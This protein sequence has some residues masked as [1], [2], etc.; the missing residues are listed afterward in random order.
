MYPCAHRKWEFLVRANN[1][2]Y[3]WCPN[4]GNV[5]ITFL[6]DFNGVL[7]KKIRYTSTNKRCKLRDT[8]ELKYSI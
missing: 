2:E 3:H 6:T 1:N 8:L 5:R 4:C 7:P